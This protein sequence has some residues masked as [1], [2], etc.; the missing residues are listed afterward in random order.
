MRI[1][2]IQLIQIQNNIRKRE[3]EEQKTNKIMVDLNQ[4]ISIITFTI[5]EPNT[6]TK[7]QRL[8][9]WIFKKARPNY[10]LVKYKN[11]ENESECMEKIYV[12]ETVSTNK[13]EWLY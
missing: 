1:L 6:P 11:R 12:M 9:E 5:N 2:N 13:I 7:R 8:P 10:M 3:R 4:T